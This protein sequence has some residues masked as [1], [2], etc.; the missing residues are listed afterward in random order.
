LSAHAIIAK[1]FEQETVMRI[2]RLIDINEYKRRQAAVGP[3]ISKR[4]FGSDRR[5]P[6]SN[7]WARGD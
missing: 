4:S 2:L 3:R 1:G 5:Y 6:I 7:L